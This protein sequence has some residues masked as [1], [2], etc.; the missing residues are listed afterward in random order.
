MDGPGW[1]GPEREGRKT[2]AL[3]HRVAMAGERGMK[4][5]IGSV[6]HTVSLRL[7]TGEEGRKAQKE[8]E[9]EK[10][11][12]REGGPDD[13]FR[14]GRRRAVAPLILINSE[15]GNGHKKEAE[16][17][18]RRGRMTGQRASGAVDGVRSATS[19]PLCRRRRTYCHRSGTFCPR[20]PIWMLDV[21]EGGKDERE[22]E[23]G[24]T[25]KIARLQNPSILSRS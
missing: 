20:G 5:L 12:G 11:G 9:A 14:R 6:R 10:G 25:S 16:R 2:T 13:S 24:G 22:R 17:G 18:K 7:A 1:G 15:I 23:G 21:Q 4:A 8:Q 19:L 3:L